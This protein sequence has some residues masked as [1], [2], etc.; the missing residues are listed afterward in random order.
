[1]MNNKFVKVY[2]NVKKGKNCNFYEF[3]IIGLPV[4]NSKDCKTIIGDNALVRSHTV[5]YCGNI[6]GN[7]FTTGH[8][9]LIREFNE[10]NDNVS[11]GSNSVEHNTK[12]GNGVRIH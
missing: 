1:M 2:P 3:S 7:N 10:I 9:V 5:I 6:I 8:F 4:S 12:I 11:I